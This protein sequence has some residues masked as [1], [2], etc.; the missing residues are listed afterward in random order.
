MSIQIRDKPISP[1]VLLAPLAGI[2]DLPFRN[3]VSS[4]GAGLVVS[5]MIASQEMVQ[6]K[7][8]VRE[9]AELGL[10]RD[11][12]AVQLA[13]REAY[14]MAE[15]ARMAE[16]NGAQLIDINMGC[17]AKKVVNGY[18]GSALLKDLDHALTL[19]EAVVAA[20]SVPVTLKTRLGW[21]DQI[22]TAPTL[23]QRA[24]S[25]GIA[26]MTIHGRTRCQFYKGAADWTA[27]AEVSHAVDIPVI[28][29]GDIISVATATAALSASKAAGVMIGRGAQ[30]R[31]WLLSE[32]ASEIEGRGQIA[33][34]RGAV[35]YDI[36][37]G[38]Y[39]AMLGFYGVDLGLRVARKHLGWYMN[40]A[41]TGAVL[42]RSILT[43][44]SPAK[45]LALL[46]LA[47]E[48]DVE[49]AA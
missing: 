42:R 30:G 37:G 26:M 8:G 17:P 48:T 33:R 22:R 15:A 44:P 16:D 6:A 32:V 49:A 35:F 46:P 31:P 2:T 21:D 38:H 9:K 5:E 11:H 43:A 34:P 29:N 14:W 39:E 19:I 20:V 4:F 10:G 40:V 18:S 3:L 36:V 12:T 47:F 24:E 13:G 45:V 28:A 25:A 27:I 41:G 7:P 23:A 1:A